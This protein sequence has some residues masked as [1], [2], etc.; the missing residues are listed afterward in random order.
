MDR[1]TA[2]LGRYQRVGE[3]RLREMERQRVSARLWE[4]DPSL[5]TADPAR[6]K[7]IKNRLG[8]MTVTEAMAEHRG[9]LAAF[10]EE[11]RGAGLTHALLLGMGGSSLC[12][13]VCRLTFGVAPGGLDLRVLDSTDPAAIRA[14]AGEAE[15]HRTLYLVSSKSGTTAETLALFRFFEDRARAEKGE[16]AGEHFVAITDPGTL[17]ERLGRERGF[18]RVFLNPADIGGRY[19]ALSLFGLVPAALLGIDVA[20][21]LERADRLVHACASSVPIAENPGIRLGAALGELAA[22]G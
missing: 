18:R 2:A 15:P 16:R 9:S 17:L 20:G 6:Q 7:A 5:W 4:R 3:E 22:A 14:R 8:W 11:A 19:S 1:Q 21:L 13:E 12:P 10:L